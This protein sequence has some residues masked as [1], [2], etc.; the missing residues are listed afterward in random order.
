MIFVMVEI[1]MKKSRKLKKFH[2]TKQLS[3][4]KIF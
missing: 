2:K 4:L 1:Y 3:M